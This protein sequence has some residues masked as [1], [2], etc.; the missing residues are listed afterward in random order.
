[1]AVVWTQEDWKRT[2]RVLLKAQKELLN[3]A[4]AFECASCLVIKKPDES[5]GAWIYEP[6][7]KKL[8][9]KMVG[10]AA[11][12]VCSQC[13]EEVEPKELRR[14]VTQTLATRGL[15]GQP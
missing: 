5:A 2:A 10:P 11:Y 3:T 4:E 7:D 13:V 9:S 6:E 12:T 14:R 15:F 1:M 8:V